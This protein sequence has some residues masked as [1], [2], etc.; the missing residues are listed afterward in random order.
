MVHMKDVRM[1]GDLPLFREF[2][3]TE[4]MM[5]MMSAQ[6]LTFDPGQLIIREST[7]GDALYVI[8]EGVV[9]IMKYDGKGTERELAELNQGECF[10]EVA[11]VD[12]EPRSASVYAKTVCVLFRVARQDFADI[13]SHHKEIERKFYKAVS[14]ILAERLR[15]AN[16]YLTFNLEVGDLI[17]EI[18]K[19]DKK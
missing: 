5:V 8:K 19:Q 2:S 3:T 12:T 16:E 11:L 10:G 15:R 17:C 6:T 13:L 7:Q 18:E 1:L 14:R 4:L 9:K